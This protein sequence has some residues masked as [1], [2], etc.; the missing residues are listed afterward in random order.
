MG[1]MISYRDERV[2]LA[3][4]YFKLYYIILGLI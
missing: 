1:R 3:E 4:T 2:Y